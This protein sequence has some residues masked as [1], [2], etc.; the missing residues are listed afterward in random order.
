MRAYSHLARIRCG[1]SHRATKLRYA[2]F[3]SRLLFASLVR[4]EWFHDCG[5]H[6][7]TMSDDQSTSRPTHGGQM[8]LV[9]TTNAYPTA[10]PSVVI[11]PT[12]PNE[13]SGLRFVFGNLRFVGS[14]RAPLL[15]DRWKMYSSCPI[16]PNVA[17]TT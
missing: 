14:R 4:N 3:R 7:P 6:L 8:E 15:T 13:V 1:K 5:P 10:S 17:H 12:N 11:D 2:V 16:G 9:P